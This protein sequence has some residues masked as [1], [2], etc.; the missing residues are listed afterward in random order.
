[1]PGNPSSGGGSGYRGGGYGGG[2][3]GHYGGRYPW[4][5]YWGGS[6]YWGGNYYYS[7]GYYYS[8]FYDRFGSY[9]YGYPSSYFYA[10]QARVTDTSEAL[11]V[12]FPPT[13][14]PL[15]APP[16]PQQPAGLILAAPS[17][18]AAYVNDP[19]Y[20]PLSTRLAK[21]NLTDKLRER[22]DSYQA[23]KSALQTELRANLDALK[24]ADQATRLRELEAFAPQQTPRIVELEKTAEQLRSDALRNGLVGLL[25]GSG[26]WNENRSW[27]LGQGRLALPRTETLSAEF[28]IIRAAVFY[29]EGLVPAQRRL[30]REVA[31]EVQVE[32]FKPKSVSASSENGSFMFFSPETARVR[33]PDDLPAEIAAKVEAYVKEKAE[34][35][36]ELRDALYVQ[37]KAT[38]AQRVLA[39]KRLAE[40]QTPRIAALEILAE[41]IRQG[42]TLQ[43][44]QP[45]PPAPPTLPPE[46]ATRI[47]AYQKEK[48]DLQKLLQNK[49]KEIGKG[50]SPTS[51]RFVKDEA[52]SRSDLHPV[53]VEVSPF[54]PTDEK[55]KLM[56]ETM[57]V[58]NRENDARFTALGKEKEG[59]RG[60]LARYVAANTETVAGKSV[61][62]LLKE[63]DDAVQKQEAWRQY[64]DYQAA[65]FEPG[66]S[67]EQRRL[68]F[69]AA[70]EKL[71][72]PLPGG[73]RLP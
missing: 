8:P 10:P 28:Q 3:G 54:L 1:M 33:L 2:G 16:P 63:F 20:A 67:P 24:G 65:V 43:S 50:L 15:G 37:D 39:L 48:L 5:S 46:L 69:N 14:P 51:V 61:E 57:A 13:P 53:K 55:Q 31:M 7:G 64:G 25:W 41:D 58:F 40:S 49:L 19:F 70:V 66:L 52:K 36:T 26:D 17:E 29:Q 22:L 30:L 18:L 35:K 4:D 60:E 73:E 21:R 11:A 72:L 44:K 12:F 34:I 45:G 38:S 42:L 9:R 32:A 23:T 56:K 47:S 27:R 62:T 71:A 6:Y 68:L 59:I